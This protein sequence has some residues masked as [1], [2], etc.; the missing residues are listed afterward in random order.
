MLRRTLLGVLPL[1]TTASGCLSTRGPTVPKGAKAPDFDLE[2]YDGRHVSL[3]SLVA[4]GP[5]VIVFY[6]GFW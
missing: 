2:S 1:L 3:D 5:A 6:R 4:N